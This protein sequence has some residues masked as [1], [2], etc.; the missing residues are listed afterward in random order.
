MR[1]VKDLQREVKSGNEARNLL[2]NDLFRGAMSSIKETLIH[3]FEMTKYDEST[4]RDEI[5]RKLQALGWVESALLTAVQS[6][7]IAGKELEK[8]RVK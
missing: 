8:A 7:T 5:W 6:G 3:G 4:E 2:D 1:D